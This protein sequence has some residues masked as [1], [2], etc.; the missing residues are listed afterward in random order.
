MIRVFRLSVVA[1]LFFAVGCSSR[2]EE[3]RMKEA[4]LKETLYSMRQA[5]DQFT[6]DKNK[7]PQD[8][9]DLVRAG[10]FRDIPKDPITNSSATWRLD[11]TQGGITDVH[12]RSNQVSSEGTRYSDW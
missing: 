10:Y 8:L 6:Q 12:S 7:A 3:I 1:I 5:I 9:E 11:Q 2:C 4:V